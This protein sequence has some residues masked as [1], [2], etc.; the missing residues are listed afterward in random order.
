MD[1]ATPFQKSSKQPFGKASRELEDWD[2]LSSAQTCKYSHIPT[3]LNAHF[4][5]GSFKMYV[6]QSTKKVF[7]IE[8]CLETFRIRI[9]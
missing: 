5:L 9:L 7:E 1:I 3:V 8:E 4:S 2:Q 6:T